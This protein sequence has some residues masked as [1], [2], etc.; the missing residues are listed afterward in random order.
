MYQKFIRRVKK[1]LPHCVPYIISNRQYW[2][3]YFEEQSLVLSQQ[4]ILQL[5]TKKELNKTESL[6]QQYTTNGKWQIMPIKYARITYP[7][8]L[9]LDGLGVIK[10][11]ELWTIVHIPTGLKIGE[12]E[13]RGEARGVTHWFVYEYDFG[14][15]T[16]EEC[17]ELIQS[18][19]L[20]VQVAKIGLNALPRDI[21]FLHETAG[22]QDDPA[23]WRKSNPNWLSAISAGASLLGALI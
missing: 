14:R 13:K 17:K 2:E 21:A 22:V 8:A 19:P 23:T 11:A 10:V 5:E 7:E 3:D 6:I 1:R 9:V 20:M 18:N 16:E 4:A 12:F 15:K